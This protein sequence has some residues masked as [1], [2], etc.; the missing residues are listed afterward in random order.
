MVLVVEYKNKEDIGIELVTSVTSIKHSFKKSKNQEEEK[1]NIYKYND[2]ECEKYFNLND[3]IDYLSYINDNKFIVVN[4]KDNINLDK[5]IKTEISSIFNKKNIEL[6]ID[7]EDELKE[8]IK[9][10]TISIPKFSFVKSFP[11]EC[12]NII[13]L[14]KTKKKLE[15]LNK[16]LIKCTKYKINIDYI[17]QMSENTEINALSFYSTSL[18]LCIFDENK[19]VSSIVI[20]KMNE[21]GEIYFDSKTKIEYENQKL[22]KLLRAT[23]I[24]IVK[25]LYPKANCVRSE[26]INPLSAYIMIKTFN[27]IAFNIDDEFDDE[28]ITEELTTLKDIKEYMALEDGNYTNEIDTKIEL[29]NE[30]I[31]NAKNVFNDVIIKMCEKISDAKSSKKKGG[32][33]S[34][35]KRIR[36]L[37]KHNKIKS[38]SK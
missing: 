37:K 16:E 12:A 22:N 31:E 9:E 7:R 3:D 13:N 19:C 21:D 24:I 17:F 8:I 1:I 23:I 6:F 38:K 29:T 11:P 36:T 4:L 5:K 14:D 26:A 27:A 25:S 35:R 20:K 2:E 18:L 32:V 15:E 30:N 33:C 34:S 28:E 10:E